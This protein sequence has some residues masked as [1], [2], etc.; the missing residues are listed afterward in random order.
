MPTPAGD[1]WACP[2][3]DGEG[4]EPEKRANLGVSA[5]KTRPKH[6]K[7]PILAPKMRS[8]VLRRV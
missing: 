1:L 6:G 2:A 3:G 7:K 4:Y 5:T 8:N